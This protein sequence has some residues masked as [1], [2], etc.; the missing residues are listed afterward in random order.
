MSNPG[1]KPN[2]SDINYL[3]QLPELMDVIGE[4]A[5]RLRT[6]HQQISDELKTGSRKKPNFCSAEASALAFD[7]SSRFEEI[8]LLGLLDQLSKDDRLQLLGAAGVG[9]RTAKIFFRLLNQLTSFPELKNAFVKTTPMWFKESSVDVATERQAFIPYLKKLESYTSHIE[10]RGLTSSNRPNISR[11][12]IETL[13]TPLYTSENFSNPVFEGPAKLF[14]S[15]LLPKYNRLLIEGEPGSGKT[16]FLKFAVCMQ[17]RDCQSQ[18]TKDGKSWSTVYL[19]F[20]GPIKIPVFL[21]L[22]Q[23]SSL[24]SQKEQDPRPDD[25]QRLLDLLLDRWKFKTYGISRKRWE[26][27]LRLGEANLFL[28]GLDEIADITMRLRVITIFRRALVAWPKCSVVV[29]SRPIDTGQLTEIGFYRALVR[30]FGLREIKRFLNRWVSALYEVNQEHMDPSSTGK[31]EYREDLHQAILGRSTIRKLARNPVM[32]TCLAIVH[33]SEGRLPEGRAQV[34]RSVIKWLLESR[35]KQREFFGISQRFAEH[36]IRTLAFLMMVHP[37]GKR[38]TIE[39]TEAAEMVDHYA[40][41]YFPHFKNKPE[42]LKRTVE[43]LRYECVFSGLI[44]EVSKGNMRFWHLTFQEFL[45]ARKLSMMESGENGPGCWWPIVKTR[46]TDPQWRETIELFPG[47]LLEGSD[48]RVDELLERVLDLGKET[49]TLADH[50]RIAG[51]AGRLLNYLEVYQYQPHP[52]W[53]QKYQNVL[54]RSTEIFTREG[55]DQ[56]PVKDRIAVAQALGQGGDPRLTSPAKNLLPVPGQPNLLIAKYPVT[57]DEYY[58]FIEARGYDEWRFWRKGWSYKLQASWEHPEDWE[59][60]LKYP[61]YPVVSVSWFEAFAYCKWLSEILSQDVSLPTEA[62]WYAAACNPDG[63][64]PWGKKI[65][66][67]EL[68]N[69]ELTMDNPTPVGIYPHG[70]S[71]GGHMDLSGNVWEWCLN[72]FSDPENYDF[73]GYSDRRALRGGSFSFRAREITSLSRSWNRAGKR[74]INYGFRVASKVVQE[75]DSISHKTNSKT[76]K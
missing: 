5:N 69:F 54:D 44:K 10:I 19:N 72:D 62:E 67:E 52:A 45:A 39:F 28:D 49:D 33:R 15:D 16:T 47:C 70:A 40:K 32:L 35:R 43:W 41:R 58:N 6:S 18:K 1:S 11:Y 42:R 7:L 76:K 36:S 31:E 75:S 9:N 14:L 29:T 38:T 8:Q 55:A 21:R 57:V 30:P 65:P 50:A 56:V 24:L 20:T 61:N 60:Q 48:E 13:H 2:L 64:W 3:L 22:S 23:L 63:D 53:R 68:S 27:I 17:A 37:K 73:P 74:R 46:L 71:L 59:M 25:E 26:N 34:Y 12:P 51:T 66:T 4:Y